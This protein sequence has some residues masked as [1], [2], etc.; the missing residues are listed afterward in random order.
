MTTAPHSTYA[1]LKPVRLRGLDGVRVVQVSAGALHSV[2]LTDHGVFTWGCG[3]G[4]RLGHGDVVDCTKPRA[5]QNLQNEVVLQVDAGSWHSA[6]VVLMAPLVAGGVVF[7]WGSG[8][9]GA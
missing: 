1:V 5:V 7:T 2:A 4:G 9:H 8:F 6:A 3:D